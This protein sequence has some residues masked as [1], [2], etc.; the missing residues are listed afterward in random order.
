M[1]HMAICDVGRLTTLDRAQ[2]FAGVLVFITWLLMVSAI[3]NYRHALELEHALTRPWHASAHALKKPRLV[4]SALLKGRHNAMLALTTASA[5]AANAES[6]MQNRQAAIVTP[7]T[8]ASISLVGGVRCG[9][10]PTERR[11][12]KQ[13][14][15]TD[16]LASHCCWLPTSAIC[17]DG[18]IPCPFCFHQSF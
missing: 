5:T 3:S 17:S 18:N 15:E 4:S 6:M 2:A 7:P 10:V 14:S 12:C 1:S 11:D 16:C 9:V 13:N 8:A